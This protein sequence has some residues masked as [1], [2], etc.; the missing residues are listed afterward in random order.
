MTHSDVAPDL[1]AWAASDRADLTPQS[2]PAVGVLPAVESTAG[3]PSIP[4]LTPD[5]HPP[6]PPQV[7]EC[8]MGGE[9][10]TPQS[11]PAARETLAGSSGAAGA[12]AGGQVPAPGGGSDGYR[13]QPP[14]GVEGGA[15]TLRPYQDAAL[16]AIDRGFARGLRRVLAVLAT[17]LGKTVLFAEWCRRRV[18]L[19]RRVIVLA[20][21]SELLEQAQRKL[22]DVG[23]RAAIEQAEKRAGY[24]P[25]IVASVQTLQGKRLHRLDPEAFDLV[26]DEA[27]HA[28]SPSY[29]KI[30]AYFTGALVLGVTA[31][32][33]RGDGQALG[34]VF[35]ECVFRY[36]IREG[37]AAGYLVKISAR[38]IFLEGLDLSSVKTRAGDLAQDQLAA[39]MAEEEAVLA[40]VDAILRETGTL[41]TIAFTVDVAHAKAIA[42]VI[43]RHRPGAARVG[44]GELER[45]ERSALLADY[46]ADR[47]QYLI[48]CQLY[49]EG[50]DEPSIACVVTLRPTKSRG[51]VVQCVGRGTR[52]LGLTYAESCAAGKRELLWLDVAGN[53]GRHRLVGP[54]D[55]LAAGEVSDD[56]R[57]EAERRMTEEACDV[58]E[59][60]ELAARDL[61]ERRERAKLTASAKYFTSDVDPFFGDMVGEP[62]LEE[63]AGETATAVERVQLDALGWKQLA[64][65]QH[66]TRGD[67]ARIFSATEARRKARLCSYKQARLL[68]RYGVD[69]REMSASGAGKRIDVLASCGWDPARARARLQQIAADELLHSD[70][71]TNQR[72]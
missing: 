66:T 15:P 58:D 68:Q 28:L 52:M 51:L 45:E 3:C 63:W 64:K 10:G 9:S 59:A 29:R 60:L 33:D 23:L 38:R 40:Q 7:R 4:A 24:A 20:H 22:R 65:S 69:A 62:V 31:T 1:F 32:A 30:V 36:E 16:I 35:E 67:A 2:N 42:E 27:H 53:A 12:P 17:G 43:N 6:T 25:V 56:V 47:F 5:P 50:F 19:G 54:I 8:G 41:K 55:A 26:I 44:H 11:D 57:R 34:D 37:I 21:R 70:N 18:M 48:N 14:I 72:T 46:R 61:E 49:T 13:L 39:I 71:Q